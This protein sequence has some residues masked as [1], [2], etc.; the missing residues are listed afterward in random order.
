MQIAYNLLRCLTAHHT[1]DE[2]MRL[3]SPLMHPRIEILQ[4]PSQCAHIEDA[5]S[6]PKRYESSQ[7]VGKLMP[8]VVK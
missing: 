2:Q 8:Y 3:D 4:E 5:F 1:L 6:Y 7:R